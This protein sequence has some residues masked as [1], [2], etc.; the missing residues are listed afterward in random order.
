MYVY[1]RSKHEMLWT[2]GFFGPKGE[3]HAESDH[4]TPEAA[5]DRVAYLNGS[6]R[7]R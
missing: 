3:W 1:I 7:A 5:A 4:S 2:V 6:V